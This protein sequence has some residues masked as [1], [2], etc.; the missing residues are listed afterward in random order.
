[1][2][3]NRVLIIYKKS[4]YQ[5]Y[6]L[7]SRSYFYKKE[8]L[9][10]GSII[11]RFI[12]AHREHYA[13][14]AKI[15]GVLSKSKISYRKL[16]RG[17]KIDTTG[18]DLIITVG[19]DGTFLEAARAIVDQPILGVN[20]APRH[21]VGR[22]CFYDANNFESALNLVLQN[23]HKIRQL[24]RINLLIKSRNK[25]IDLNVLNDV[26][27]C[28]QN[29]AAL[30]RYDLS[31]RG[32]REEHRNS[33]LWVSTAAGSTG[34]IHSAGGELIPLESKKIQYMPREL[35]KGFSARYRLR[36]GILE[37]ESPIVIESLMADGV[38]YADG[39]N[40]KYPFV[41][42]DKIKI[43]NSIFPTRVIIP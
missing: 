43:R 15:E 6:F 12:G 13:S 42:G 20:S 32:M 35:Y 29:P 8:G 36:G 11:K 19:G 39:A 22:L 30:S 41:F 28:N 23:R 10:K 21:S 27:I 9:L 33:G 26:L 4:A 17:N 34:A 38:V 3:A 7:E 37:L 18:F 1:M 40:L 14:L 2:K 5:I 24:N 16:Y 25:K 31:I